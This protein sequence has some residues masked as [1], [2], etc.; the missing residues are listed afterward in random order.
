MAAASFDK[1]V[2]ILE[3]VDN[4]YSINQT[5]YLSNLGEGAFFTDDG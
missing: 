2:Y 3:A 1:F 4:Q 5:I